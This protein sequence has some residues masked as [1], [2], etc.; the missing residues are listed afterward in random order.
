MPWGHRPRRQ[1]RARSDAVPGCEE[2]EPGGRAGRERRRRDARVQGSADA[3]ADHRRRDLR[4]AEDHEQQQV[5]ALAL[6]AA[7]LSAACLASTARA[8]TEP[9]LLMHVKVALTS[10]KIS[11]SSSYAARGLEVE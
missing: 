2:H 3:E 6:A 10:S 11:L 1:R 4:D 8:T 9:A 7:A 5:R